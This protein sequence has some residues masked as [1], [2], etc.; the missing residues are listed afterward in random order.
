M[1]WLVAVLALLVVACGPPPAPTAAPLTAEGV[2][3]ALGAS[4]LP[5]SDVRVLT[6]ETDP[7]KLL[8]R[9][10]QYVGK[11][12]WR[13][14]RAGEDACKLEVFADRASMQR[15]VDYTGGLAKASPLLVE[16]V[17][18]HPSK[19]AVMRLPKELTPDQVAAYRAWF[20]RL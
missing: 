19:P 10:G 6:A 14:G 17:E 20:A 4:G 13:D 12:N 18:P 3:A 9:P 8:G 5:V 15:W 16:Y 11:I 2:A 7:N 1:R